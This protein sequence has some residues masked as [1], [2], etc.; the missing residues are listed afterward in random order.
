MLTGP[1]KSK[2]KNISAVVMISM[3]FLLVSVTSISSCTGS[4]LTDLADYE[5][6]DGQSEPYTIRTSADLKG[7]SNIVNGNDGRIAY[8]FTGCIIELEADIDLKGYDWLPIGLARYSYDIDDVIDGDPVFSGTFDGKGHTIS[9][10]TVNASNKNLEDYSAGL[11]GTIDRGEIKNLILLDC[12]V[13]GRS[14]LGMLAGIARST[15]VN[16]I[17]VM[18]GSVNSV[19]SS[20]FCTGGIIGWFYCKGSPSEYHGCTL[21]YC[22]NSSDIIVDSS[23]I[24]MYTGGITGAIES[25]SLPVA[26]SMCYNT[27]NITV[28]SAVSSSMIGGI[29]GWEIANTEGDAT[30]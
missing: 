16:N 18:N 13:T 29:S 15:N 4:A 23:S 6:Y 8:D 21:E 20:S 19:G 12:K 1:L 25:L 27:G 30:I 2:I 3:I 7:L 11:F 17:Y 26:L 22:S 10:M 24:S 5:W 9:N 14:D 28:R